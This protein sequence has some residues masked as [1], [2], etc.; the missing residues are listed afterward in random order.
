[1]ARGAVLG[2]QDRTAIKH[3]AALVLDQIGVIGL[4]LFLLLGLHPPFF[5]AVGRALA[6]EVGEPA[7]EDGD[8]PEQ[9][10]RPQQ[11]MGALDRVLHVGSH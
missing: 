5:A 2:V 9:P 6:V 3:V 10:R 1:M 11:G 7:D 8:D 4:G